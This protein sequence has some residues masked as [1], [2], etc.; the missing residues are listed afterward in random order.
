ME[1]EQG[2]YVFAHAA[3]CYISN[4]PDVK[5]SDESSAV[6]YHLPPSPQFK[7]VENFR[8]VIS[9]YWTPWVNHTTRYS[10]GEFIVGEVLN[11][12]FALQEAANIYSIKAHQEFVVVASSK[13]LLVLRCKKAEECQFP[14]NLHA[15]LVKDTCLFVIH[16]YKGSHTYVN[17]YLN[18]EH[19]QLDSNLVVA[20]IKAIIKAQFTLSVIAIQASVME[21]LGYEIPY[22]KA[23]DGKHKAL[24][25]L[26]G[27]FY[28][29]YTEL[30]RLFLALEQENPRCIVIWKTFDSNMSN[31][32]IFQSVFWSFKPSIEGFEHC[33]HVLSIDG[34]HFYVKYKN[35]LMISM[36]CDGNN[37]LFPLAFAITKGEN[38]DS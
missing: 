6:Q 7:H 25:N 31:T 35:M 37:Q 13:K 12:K 21:K 26:F 11:S 38:I 18:K 14:W 20:H 3:S 8:N 16:K 4:N 19:H 10:S 2:I 36:G 5:E 32:E 33:R 22:K 24:R 1:N 23:L 15:M 29:S 9:S 27:D 17:C 30:S 28:Q 34:T